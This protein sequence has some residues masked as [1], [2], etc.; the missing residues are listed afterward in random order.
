LS[1]LSTAEWAYDCEDVRPI[2]QHDQA[3]IFESYPITRRGFK[4]CNGHKYFTNVPLDTATRVKEMRFQWNGLPGEITLQKISLR[5]ELTEQSWPLSLWESFLADDLRWRYIE[6][7]QDATIYENLRALPRVRLVP[8][9]ISLTADEVLHA[10]KFSQLPNGQT[11]DPSQVALVEEPLSPPG[12]DSNPRATAEIT[13]SSDTYIR[14]RT[15]STSQTYLV[16]NDLYYPGW[17]AFID[18]VPVHIYRTNYILRGVSIPDGNHVVEFKYRPKTFYFGILISIVSVL[19]VAC[20]MY[21]S[22]K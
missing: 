9:V 20:I 21:R 14:I 1:G 11:Y 6:D 13:L 16:L 22:Q 5:N 3:P 8:R 15:E 17:L 10:I 19:S 7:I 12:L 4:A 18:K 2:I